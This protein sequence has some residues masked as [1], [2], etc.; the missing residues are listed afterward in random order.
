L[1][2]SEKWYLRRVE[3]R[4]I[5][6]KKKQRSPG[7]EVGKKGRNKQC[8]QKELAYGGDKMARSQHFTRSKTI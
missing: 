4:N 1:G 8:L 7:K 6:G 2:K 3:K 5:H